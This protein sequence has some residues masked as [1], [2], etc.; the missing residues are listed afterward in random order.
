MSVRPLSESDIPQVAD[1]YW[2]YMRR[3]EGSAP[4]ALHAFLLEL[5][6]TNPFCDSA[7]PSLV[8]EAQDGRV[9]GFIGGSVRKMSVCG[10]PIRVVFGGNLV[11]HPEFRSGTA[12][13][14]LLDR[15]LAADYDLSVTD[16]A[17]DISRKILQRM[18]L[19]LIPALNIHWARPLQPIRYAVHTMVRSTG[20]VATGV[21]FAAKPF[22][23]VADILATRLTAS[24]FRHGESNLHGGELDVATLLQCLGEF[25]K[26]YSLCPEYDMESLTWLLNFMERRPSRGKLRKIVVRDDAQKLVGWYIYYV[27]PGAIGEVVQIGGAP[28]STKS[29]LD[30]LFNDAWEQGVIALH[31]MVDARRMADFSDKGCFFTCRGGWTIINPRKPGILELLERGDAFFSR[32]D[33]E[34]ALDPGD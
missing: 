22:C 21:K 9:V 31:G 5:F 32:L 28:K 15:F 34:W 14:R 1:L 2:K 6:F 8:Y 25:R 23:S 19:H 10:E 20:I 27:K 4:P 30:H 33:G 29:I 26:G 17:N 3:R 7:S 18:G 24:P 13:P 11:V 12:A 16:S